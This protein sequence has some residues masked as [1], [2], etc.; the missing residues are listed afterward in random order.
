MAFDAF[1]KIEGIDGDSTDD[2]HKSWMEIMA[3]NFAI[4]RGISQSSSGGGGMASGRPNWTQL[5]I[6][7]TIDKSTPLLFKA[8]AEAQAIKKVTLELC[9]G[10]KQKFMQ[11]VMEDC[12]ISSYS[13]NGN[14]GGADELPTES[15]SIAFS[16]MEFIYT[17]TDQ[18]TGAPKG[19][20]MHKYDLSADKSV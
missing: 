12:M 15:V 5:E 19:D 13:P 8:L 7:K 10:Q 3:F 2:K 1:L 11:Y 17:D 6:V 16:S 4:D 14:P 9:R 20:I 18:R